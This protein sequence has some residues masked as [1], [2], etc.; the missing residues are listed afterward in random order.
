MEGR[1]RREGKKEG[2]GRVTDREGEREG[3]EKRHA[4]NNEQWHRLKG[5]RACWRVMLGLTLEP[6]MPDGVRAGC[7]SK[8][9]PALALAF[10]VNP[11]C[12]P[13][14]GGFL[15]FAS[16]HFPRKT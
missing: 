1:Q 12:L 11:P 8:P 14:Q 10:P 4:G 7:R 13:G 5:P 9:L 6:L 16:K 15:S 2:G 3:G